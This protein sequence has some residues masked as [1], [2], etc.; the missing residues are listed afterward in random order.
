MGIF[1]WLFKRNK[2]M[3]LS[4][5]ELIEANVCP[6]CWGTQEYQDKFIEYR[7]DNTKANI[8]ND[9]HGQKAFVAQFVETHIS[10]IQLKRESDRSHCPKCKSN[11]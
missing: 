8:N 1:D 7:K 5:Q 10:G 3:S 11:F 9:K 2:S 6:N 4:E